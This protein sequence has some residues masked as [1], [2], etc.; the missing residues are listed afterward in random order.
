MKAVILAA[1]RGKRM[2][3]LTEHT[4]KPLIRVNNK[5][6]LGYA[7]DVL[8]ENVSEIIILVN[9][10]GEQIVNYV[11][12]EYPHKNIIF[13]WQDDCLGTANALE[14]A[15]P[16]LI[17]EKF[18]VLFA[19]DIHSKKSVEECLKYDLALLVQEAEH[20]ER[21]G[22]VGIK[23]G[24]Y[25]KNIIEKPAKPETNLV[26]AGIHVLDDRIFK[27]QAKPHEN[28]EFYLTD[29]IDQ[30][31][32]DYPVKAVTTDFWI[33]VGYPEDIKRAEDI[34]NAK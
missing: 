19:D 15:K 6:L 30:L 29:L 14:L 16:H 8:P 17:G 9:Y 5:A 10:L 23:E 26:N 32:Q 13:I 12:K 20:P 27:Y 33:S 7:I 1:G 31:A 34:L 3:P 2:M 21:F 18:I 4:P 22:V 24:S 25:V 11:K 28:G